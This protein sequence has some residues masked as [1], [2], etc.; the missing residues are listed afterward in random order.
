VVGE[1]GWGGGRQRTVAA[2]S[3][4]AGKAY[5]RRKQG[6]GSSNSPPALLRPSYRSICYCYPPPHYLPH[7]RLTC[8]LFRIAGA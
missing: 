6:Y 7:R 5:S 3:Q 8:T 1:A 4:T 2:G